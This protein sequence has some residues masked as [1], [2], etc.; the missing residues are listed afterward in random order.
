MWV[1]LVSMLIVD[2]SRILVVGKIVE[3]NCRKRKENE[4]FDKK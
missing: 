3:M 2:D 4:L 1:M